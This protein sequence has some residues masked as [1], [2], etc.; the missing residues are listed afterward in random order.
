MAKRMFR[1]PSHG[2]W[3]VPDVLVRG[4]RREGNFREPKE[5]WGTSWTWTGIGLDVS[6]RE[7]VRSTAPFKSRGWGSLVH[8]C[9][10][11]VHGGKHIA[12]FA[13]HT[14]AGSAVGRPRVLAVTLSQPG[15]PNPCIGP[16]RGGVRGL[17]RRR[18]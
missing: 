2:D 6:V 3:R 9:K 5:G 13:R 4:S 7:N 14:L 1:R 16:L 15:V 11:A 17:C 18:A 8:R 12:S 10:G